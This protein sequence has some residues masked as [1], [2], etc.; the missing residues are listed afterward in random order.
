MTTMT[1]TLGRA[2]SFRFETL[3]PAADDL[4]R[5]EWHHFIV[6]GDRAR[7]IVN[8]SIGDREGLPDPRP[9]PRLIVLVHHDDDWSGWI[10]QLDYDEVDLGASGLG[11]RFGP[12]SIDF[13][14]GGYEIDVRIPESG[15]RGRLRFTPKSESLVKNNQPLGAGRFTWLFV[16]RLTV[17]GH[18]WAGG[19]R[20]GMREALGYHDHNWGR[21]RWGDDF[22][23]QWGSVLAS[24]PDNPWSL[25]FWRMS[26]RSRL[27]TRGQGLALWRNDR[28]AAVFRD[29][30]VHVE[31]TGM[32]QRSPQ[33]IL[34]P[35]MGITNP[36]SASDIPRRVAIDAW[37]GEDHVGL[38]ANVDNYGRIVV[39]S[40]SD[41]RDV[42][43]HEV[44]VT[45]EASG[46]VDGRPIEMGG[47][48]VFEF[49]G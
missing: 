44:S 48:G 47:T 6:Q 35:A 46:K 19:V 40:D 41:A 3:V 30:L 49:L 21:F 22:A 27:A 45:V 28:P 34:P 26:D 32:L 2:D 39:P 7:V 10:S 42:V 14:D 31:G 9:S 15:V 11:A 17:D 1:G 24:D 37:R 16:P 43:I 33:V 5:Q 13:H 20:Y 29:S 25:V 38:V 4:P 23:W 36:G 12:S 8:F 18:L